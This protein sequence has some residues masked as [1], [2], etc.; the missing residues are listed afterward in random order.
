MFPSR[1]NF[2]IV[3]YMN[4]KKQ[5]IITIILISGTTLFADDYNDPDTLYIARQRTTWR[6]GITGYKMFYSGDSELNDKFTGIG[7]GF[8]DWNFYRGRRLFHTGPDLFARIGLRHFEAEKDSD[9]PF[10]RDAMINVLSPGIGIRYNYGF[11]LMHSLLQIYASV[12]GEVVY[13]NE[14]SQD[15]SGANH[16][17][18]LG[19]VAGA[20]FEFTPIPETGFFVEYNFGYAPVGNDKTNIEGHQVYL[21]ATYRKR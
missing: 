21:G 12:H 20:G 10:S 14:K 19:A 7:G 2:I 9:N 8:V 6:L 15:E 17:V 1:F 3:N 11:Q 13:S 4:I 18:S 16:F 5:I